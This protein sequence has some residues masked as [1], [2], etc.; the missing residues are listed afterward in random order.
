M[1]TFTKKRVLVAGALLVAGAAAFAYAKRAHETKTPPL[2]YRASVVDTGSITHTVTATG[3]INPVALVNV[4]PQASDKVVE[5][6]AD[7]ND[8]AKKG[9]VLLKLGPTIFNAVKVG[10]SARIVACAFATAV[11]CFWGFIQQEGRRA[12][13]P[14]IVCGMSKF[15]QGDAYTRSKV[16][17]FEAGTLCAY[18]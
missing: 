2:K 8:R 11:G 7:F 12:C 4:G 10:P 3:T 15:F 16:H 17:L 5:L 9:Q 6:H 18:D 13:C 14:W 1:K